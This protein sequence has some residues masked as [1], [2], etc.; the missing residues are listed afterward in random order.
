MDVSLELRH[1]L[2]SGN[3]ISDGVQEVGTTRIV[4]GA[5]HGPFCSTAVKTCR[6]DLPCSL[7]MLPGLNRGIERMQTTGS[8]IY[9]PMFWRIWSVSAGY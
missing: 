9:V 2:V 3:F 5:M 4:P 8:D 6:F 1:G 7:F